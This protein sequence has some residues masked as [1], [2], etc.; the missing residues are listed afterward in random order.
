MNHKCL[1][2]GYEWKTLNE[3]PKVCPKC[4]SYYWK[5]LSS[6]PKSLEDVPVHAKPATSE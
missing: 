3:N 4:K 5:L 1:R 2:C 6:R